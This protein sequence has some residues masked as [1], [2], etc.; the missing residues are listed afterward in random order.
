MSDTDWILYGANGYTGELIAREAVARGQRPIL[1]GRNAESITKLAVE[2]GC[3]HRVF[4]LGNVAEAVR[5][6]AG[7]RA[8]LHC[9]GPFA[10][11]A[12]P[13][14]EACTTITPR[15]RVARYSGAAKRNMPAIND[16]ATGMPHSGQLTDGLRPLSA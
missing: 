10:A 6:L 13:M 7:A 12:E 8:V 2:L 4:N 11:T 1:A 5:G 14:M 9:A 16:C 3:S 15:W